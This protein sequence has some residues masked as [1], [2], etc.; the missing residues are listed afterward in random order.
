MRDTTR[1]RRTPWTAFAVFGVVVF[2]LPVAVLLLSALSGRWSFPHLLPEVWGLRGVL[3]LA[4]RHREILRSLASSTG[5]SLLTVLWAFGITVLPASVLGRY[6]F[7]GRLLLEALFLSPVLI[8][9]ITYGMGIHFVFIRIGMA[10]TVPGVVFVLA[11][12]AYPYMLRALI[13]GFQQIDPDYDGCA[14]N[15][16][17]TSWRR[18]LFVHI[19]LL[20]PAIVSGASVVFLVAFSEYFLVFLIGGGAVDS[21]TGYLF[22]FLT[23]GDRTL[24]AALTLVFLVIPLTLFAVVDRTVTRFYERRGIT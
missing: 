23:G 24:G 18:L 20:G 10:N 17:A 19:P 4:E 11:A 22:P 5:Y 7:R 6:E 9:A 14:A 12:S 1:V 3:F 2:L 16:G 13:A 8:P 21:Y 15:L